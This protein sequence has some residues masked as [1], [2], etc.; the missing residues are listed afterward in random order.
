[1]KTLLLTFTALLTLIACGAGGAA[2][3][4]C[5][6]DADCADG[7]ECH[8]EEHDDHDDEDTAAHEEEEEHE[9]T[10]VCEDH[11]DHDHE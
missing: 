3:D 10:G 5:T 4:S 9:E 7:L 6:T 11:E 8:I 2:G 1:M